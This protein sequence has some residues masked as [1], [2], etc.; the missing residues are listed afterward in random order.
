[1]EKIVLVKKNCRRLD[2]RGVTDVK[3]VFCI[4]WTI[5]FCFLLVTDTSVAALDKE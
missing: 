5:R 2:H 4:R 1:M 3:F